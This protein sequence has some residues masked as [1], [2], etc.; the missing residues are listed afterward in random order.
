MKILTQERYRIVEMPREVWITKNG[1]QYEIMSTYSSCRSLGH[2]STEKRAIEV[3]REIF[4][5]YGI[6]EK[7]IMPRN[8]KTPEQR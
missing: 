8:L 3:L 5:A 4:A 2:Y 7:Y 6:R 1:D